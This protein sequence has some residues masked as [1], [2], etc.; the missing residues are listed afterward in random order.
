M[1][2]RHRRYQDSLAYR[3]PHCG[4]VVDTAPDTGGG[5]DLTY[6]EDCPICCRSNRIRTSFVADAETLR[7]EVSPEV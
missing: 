2:R 7:I 3:C 6:I 1:E 4:N 5:F